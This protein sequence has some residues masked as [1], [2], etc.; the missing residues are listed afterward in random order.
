MMANLVSIRTREHAEALRKRDC[1]LR[2]HPE[3][4]KLQHE[5]DLQLDKAATDHNRLVVIHNLMM[6]R[7]QQLRGKLQS[8]I[9]LS[10]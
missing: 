8:F 6:D 1:F 3:L 5:I 9:R 4:L 7:F 10:S 2:S